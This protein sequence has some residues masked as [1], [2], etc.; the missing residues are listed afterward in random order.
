MSSIE[1]SSVAAVATLGSVLAT[2][3][4]SLVHIQSA[5]SQQG[6]ARMS[7]DKLMN[8]SLARNFLWGNL[9]LGLIVP[10]L[11]V[12]A[13]LAHVLPGGYLAV[14]GVLLLAGNFMA[15]HALLKAGYYASLL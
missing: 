7:A 10:G 1:L 15:K 6:A 5:R 11:I 2:L 4:F 14:A 13:H 3:V 12:V 9:V 8:G